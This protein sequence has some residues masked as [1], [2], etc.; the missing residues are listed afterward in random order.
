MPTPERF[1]TRKEFQESLNNWEKQKVFFYKK[2]DN[3]DTDDNKYTWSIFIK[4]GPVIGQMTIQ[5]K[6]D[7]P[8]IRGIGWFID[9]KYQGNGYAK[10]A[11]TE[12]LNYMFKEVGIDKII[13]STAQINI[14]SPKLLKHFGFQKTGKIVTHYYEDNGTPIPSDEY[15]LTK[16]M[17]ENTLL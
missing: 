17:F 3:L 14:P 12:I 6:S 8:K 13:T 7:N 16:E 5:P 4:N 2:V 9:P 15:I 10:E 1:K 11:A